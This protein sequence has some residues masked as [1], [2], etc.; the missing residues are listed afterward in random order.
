MTSEQSPQH[1]QSFGSFFIIDVF[2]NGND[3]ELA[4]KGYPWILENE[5]A[6]TFGVVKRHCT[7]P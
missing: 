7:K 2:A 6:H 1:N 4:E 3:L 5:R